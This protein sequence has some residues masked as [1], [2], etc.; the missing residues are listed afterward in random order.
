[1]GVEVGQLLVVGGLLSLLWLIRRIPVD[2]PPLTTQ[3]PVYLMGTVS[4]YWF[5]DRVAGLL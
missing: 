5:I 2:L 3:L 4:A 1:M